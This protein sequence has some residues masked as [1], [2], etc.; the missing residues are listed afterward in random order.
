M[1]VEV[2]ALSEKRN[3]HLNRVKAVEKEKDDLEADK[4]EAERVL[5][6]QNEVCFHA[7]KPPSRLQTLTSSPPT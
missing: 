4:K 3:E 2:E 6:M 1:E 7:T 5:A